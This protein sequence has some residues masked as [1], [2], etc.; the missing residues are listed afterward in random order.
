MK[1]LNLIL[2][3]SL[4][5][6]TSAC[7]SATPTPVLEPSPSA[8]LPVTSTPSLTP[9]VP[10]S[11]PS[12]TAT[13]RLLPGE[14]TTL[15]NVRSGPGT[16]F[17][18]LDYL[19]AGTA[20]QVEVQSED[21]NWLRILHAE[22]P[23]GRGWV[24]AEYI[25]LPSGERVPRELTPTPDGFSGTVLIRVNVRGGPGTSF[26]SLGML[27]DGAVVTLLA[28]NATAS[29]FQ[30]EYPSGSD[31]VGW[32]TA[33]YIQTSYSADLPVVDE[34]GKPISTGTPGPSPTAMLAT[35]TLGAAPEDGDSITLPGGSVIF[36]SSG[37]RRFTYSGMVSNPN[38]DTEDWVE[39][40]PFSSL[41]GSQARLLASLACQGGSLRIELWQAGA[42]LGGWGELACGDTGQS[43]SI[44]AGSAYQLRLLAAPGD[45]LQLISYTLVMENLP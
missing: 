20:V 43:L 9:T 44:P 25:L 24:A 7:A 2:L 12:L 32:V 4:L 18:I 5:V 42:V 31:E 26:E 19:Q 27:E 22:A 28:K 45:G 1:N 41:P 29:W 21:G 14:T 39:F 38:G 16:E 40:T 30:V 6:A 10:T 37:T 34:F 35:P 15:V 33:Q 8:T 3:I 23:E 11:T 13:P 17:E 36:S